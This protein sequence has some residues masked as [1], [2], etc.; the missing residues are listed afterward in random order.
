M[1][2]GRKEIEGKGDEKSRLS[3]SLP[4]Y[5]TSANLRNP[6]DPSLPSFLEACKAGSREL[7]KNL[8]QTRDG[9]D[10]SLTLGLT[11]AAEADNV[12]VVLYLLESGVRWDTYT[13]QRAKSIEVFEVLFNH[14]FTMNDHLPQSSILLTSAILRNNEPLIKWL[15]SHG[16]RPDPN[17]DTALNSAA[18]ISTSAIFDLLLTNGAN[19]SNAIPLHSAAGASSPSRP[20]ERVPM[21][22]H[23]IKLGLDPNADDNDSSWRGKGQVLR[24]ADQW[25]VVTEEVKCLLEHGADPYAKGRWGRSAIQDAIRRDRVGLVE[26]YR[27]YRK[28][29]TYIF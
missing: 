16:A 24:Y 5:I 2:F 26:E 28:P 8:A 21:L 18:A 20:G 13:L 6:N 11:K 15:L 9:T 27:K 4:A 1:I 23:L 22:Q 12:A 17:S 19:L 3:Y 14:G 29:G 7:V 10:G 25:G